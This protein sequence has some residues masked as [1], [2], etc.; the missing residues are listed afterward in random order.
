MD[1]WQFEY[2]VA[3]TWRKTLFTLLGWDHHVLADASRK[4]REEITARFT[5]YGEQ[6]R[7][8]LG[9]KYLLK[10]HWAKIELEGNLER[11][12]KQVERLKTAY[13]QENFRVFRDLRRKFD[14]KGVLMN[15]LIEGLFE[16]E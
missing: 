4:R 8:T 3:F 16:S 14:P 15:E 2:N 12:K 5:E 11:R 9:D 6:M 7:D 10:T 1:E 13:G